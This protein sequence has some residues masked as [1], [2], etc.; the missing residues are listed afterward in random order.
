LC[1][2]FYRDKK[3]VGVFVRFRALASLQQLVK[4]RADPDL[5]AGST[6]RGWTGLVTCTRARSAPLPAVRPLFQ[7]FESWGTLGITNFSCSI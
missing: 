3:V 2:S 1:T 4:D 7:K 6:A 5:L